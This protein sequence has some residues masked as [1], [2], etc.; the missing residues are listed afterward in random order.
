MI[1]RK[2]VCTRSNKINIKL[3]E[4]QS[5]SIEAERELTLGLRS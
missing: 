4:R 2:S 5:S 1:E 3:K